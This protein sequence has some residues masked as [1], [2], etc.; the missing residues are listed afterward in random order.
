ML[1]SVRLRRGLGVEVRRSAFGPLFSPNLKSCFRLRTISMRAALRIARVAAR[2]A[3]RPARTALPRITAPALSALPPF[4]SASSARPFSSS[5]VSLKK[6]GKE[7]G[8]KK[9]DKGG[10]KKKDKDEDEEAGLSEAE[11]D[12]IVD[13]TKGKMTKSVDWAKSVVFEGVERGRGRVSPGKS[14]TVAIPQHIP[15]D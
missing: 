2:A 14:S 11:I 9:T 8:A 7:K 6:G 15:E 3:P 10:K 4:A 12:A 5:H 13:K 1:L